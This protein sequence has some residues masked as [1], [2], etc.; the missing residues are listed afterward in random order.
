[1]A[2]ERVSESI[3]VCIKL[4]AE[5]RIGL[6]LFTFHLNLKGAVTDH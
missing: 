5:A 1:M 4:S 2:F 6:F 3:S